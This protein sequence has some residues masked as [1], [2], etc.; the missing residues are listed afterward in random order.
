MRA[1][2]QPDAGGEPVV[3]AT[4]AASAAVEARVNAIVGRGEESLWRDLQR[5]E[6]V[7]LGQPSIDIDRSPLLAVPA[8]DVVMRRR[9]EDREG[10]RIV[11]HYD[12]INRSVRVAVG[13]LQRDPWQ[14]PH[15]PMGYHQKDSAVVC[16]DEDV[17][18]VKRADSRNRSE[19]RNPAQEFIM[20]AWAGAVGKDAEDERVPRAHGPHRLIVDAPLDRRGHALRQWIFNI[21]LSPG[22]CHR[23][24][25]VK[26]R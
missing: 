21:S 22:I 19:S 8:Q 1:L 3:T 23:P 25:I 15:A 9:I 17:T 5:G 20:H 18:T 12:P 7:C 26:A 11:Y 24:R 2:R 13:I 6:S 4:V 14:L 16:A 10:E